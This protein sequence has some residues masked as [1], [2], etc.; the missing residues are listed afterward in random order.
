MKTIIGVLIG[1]AG[2]VLLASLVVE[3][4]YLSFLGGD[5]AYRFV[6]SIIGLAMIHLGYRLVTSQRQ[7]DHPT[8]K[9]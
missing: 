2:A 7:A 9:H 6:F 8:E 5:V 1:I 4:S 3:A